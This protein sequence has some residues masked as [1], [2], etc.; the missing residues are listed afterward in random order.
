MIVVKTLT[1]LMEKMKVLSEKFPDINW[2]LIFA[3][4]IVK[5]FESGKDM[6]IYIPIKND[7]EER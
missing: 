2:S 5:S 3:R 4:A 1:E 7:L 6:P